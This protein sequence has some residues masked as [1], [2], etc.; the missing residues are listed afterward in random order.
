M[1]N[2]YK[3]VAT[4]CGVAGAFLVAA[5]LSISK[6]GFVSFLISVLMWAGAAVKMRDRPLLILNVVYSAINL[7]GIARWFT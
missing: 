1:F 6:W 4:A 2:S 5:H 7:I 3:W